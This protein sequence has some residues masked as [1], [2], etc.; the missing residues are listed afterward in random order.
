M[1]VS[2]RMLSRLSVVAAILVPLA[3]LAR[4]ESGPAVYAALGLKARDV[5]NGTVLTAQVLPGTSKQVVALV[6]C[7]TGKRDDAEAVNVRLAV[8]QKNGENLESVYSRDFGKEN[9]GYVGRGELTL[10]DLDG[11][12]VSE[13][14]VTY[15]NLKDRL[16]VERR[17][18]IL[19]HEPPG[20][21]VVWSG[22]MEYDATRAAR[23]LPSER[24]DRFIRRIDIPATLKTR[25]LTLLMTKRVIA[26]AGERLAEPQEAREAFPLRPERD[27]PNP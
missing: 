18:E 21:R 19:S 23:E 6:T 5:L 25:G 27:A 3:G 7:F 22:A 12:G 11:D 8:F 9:G 15:D 13:I 26:V 17:G 4:A 20:F 16:I 10:V 14:V 24:R 1:I 2:A